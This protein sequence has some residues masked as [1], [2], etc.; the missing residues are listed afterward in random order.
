MS[1]PRFLQEGFEKQL[2]HFIE[3]A[4]EAL[5]AAGKTQ[6]WGPWSTNPLLKE[7]DKYFDETNF[8]WLKRELDDVEEAIKRLRATMH[9]SAEMAKVKKP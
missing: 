6:R 1:D 9:S 4:G 3:E 8:H 7:G 5:A 2:A